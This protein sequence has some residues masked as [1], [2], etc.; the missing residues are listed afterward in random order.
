MALS[1]KCSDQTLPFSNYQPTE[2]IHIISVR[3]NLGMGVKRKAYVR[4]PVK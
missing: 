2:G 1:G 3:F 4:N